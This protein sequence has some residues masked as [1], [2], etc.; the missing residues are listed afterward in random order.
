M[1]LA[2]LIAKP[3]KTDKA[4][5]TKERLEYARIMVEVKFN[6]ELP[7]CIEFL[8]EFGNTLKQ[9]V[10][11]EWKPRVCRVCGGIGHDD[12]QCP[13]H[14]VQARKMEGLQAGRNQQLNKQNK[15]PQRVWKPV[16]KP[17][18]KSQN[19]GSRTNTFTG[20][21]Q[22]D[23]ICQKPQ[24]MQACVFLISSGGNRHH[25]VG[26]FG[27][28][29]TKVKAVKFGDVF[30][31]LGSDWS[32]CTNYPYHKGVHKATGV[33]FE[34]TMVYGLNT[35]GARVQLWEQI[36]ELSNKV[37]GPWILQGD[38][39]NVLN[40]NDRIGSIVSLAEV[41][42][43][44]SCLRGA[45]LTN[46][47]TGGMFYTWNN[48]QEGK[49]RV[50]SK[51]DRVIVNDEWML[52]FA[53][54]QATFFP[55]GLM[56]HSPC[57]IKLFDSGNHTKKPF[58]FVNIWVNSPDFLP[59]VKEVWGKNVFGTLMFQCVKKLKEVK[60]FLKEYKMGRFSCVE[61]DDVVAE[62]H[63]EEIQIK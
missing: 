26:L 2:S 16:Q 8:D 49:D 23:D 24:L 1:K 46:W 48:K 11:Y 51:I 4:T 38:F 62:K 53:D 43:F 30:N 28:L 33:K 19:D 14:K 50:C 34:C 27:L 21:V 45:G 29:K 7:E 12:T 17:D 54:M 13:N 52:K 47:A 59:G 31:R 25:G 55:E 39:N 37:S 36:V 5:A 63:L 20:D 15:K 61:V 40:L 60:Q 9:E 10:K 44:R 22:A 57:V 18:I 3:I 6:V 32:V 41:E 42:P 56:D 58:R 35:A